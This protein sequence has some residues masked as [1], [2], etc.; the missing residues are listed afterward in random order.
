MGPFRPSARQTLKSYYEVPVEVIED[1][2]ALAAWAK[3]AIASREGGE[4][5]APKKPKKNKRRQEGKTP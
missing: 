1:A 2:D 5:R 3:R 4:R